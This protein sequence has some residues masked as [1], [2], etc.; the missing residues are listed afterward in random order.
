VSRVVA[1]S[2][3][4]ALV[5]RVAVVGSGG[6]GKTTFARELSRRT[7][8]TVVHLD[9]LYWRP[10]WVE[11]PSDEWR[12]LLDERLIAE[13]WIVDGNYAGTFDVR[14]SRSDTIVVLALSRWRCVARALKRTIANH[15]RSVQAIGCPE[16]ID[17]KFLRWVW[18]YEK[19]SRPT[20]D[21]A[22]HEHGATSKVIEL[23]TPR[24]VARFFEGLSSGGPNATWRR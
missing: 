3:K 4:V 1:S 21:A 19:D 12:T 16:R 9:H 18:R 15:G 7:G 6:A 17:V 2:E 10:G 5:E 24:E 20:L 8:L 13:Q 11:T 14:F 23:R 22:I